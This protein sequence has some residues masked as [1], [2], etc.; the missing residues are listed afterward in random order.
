[1]TKS[2]LLINI[3]LNCQSKN[4]KNPIGKRKLNLFN[5]GEKEEFKEEEI[6]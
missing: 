1:M 2:I 4:K 6:D 3:I 5:K